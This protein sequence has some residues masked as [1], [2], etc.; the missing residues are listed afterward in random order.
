MQRTYNYARFSIRDAVCYRKV[1]ETTPY[2][3]DVD[4][5]FQDFKREQQAQR[6]RDSRNIDKYTNVNAHPDATMASLED[7]AIRNIEHQA[8]VKALNHLNIIQK[9]RLFAYYYQNLTYQ[10]IAEFEG[11]SR[12]AVTKT[13]VKA[14]SILKLK[15]NRKN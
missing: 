12:T 7:T 6:K 10:Q 11:V 9:R 13:I 1:F 14:L 5:L 4:R 15:L 2:D 8:L 3:E